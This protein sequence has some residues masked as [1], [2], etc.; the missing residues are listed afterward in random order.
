MHC[1]HMN[2]VARFLTITL[3]IMTMID[4]QAAEKRI[5]VGNKNFTEQYIVG[6][7]IKQMLED[8]GFKVDLKSDLTSMAL[9]AGM[10]SGDIDICADY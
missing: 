1:L 2:I 6:Q 3:I 4:V 9:R 8:R 5:T 10:E 7:L